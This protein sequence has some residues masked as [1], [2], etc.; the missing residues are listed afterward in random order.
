[1]DRWNIK[2]L[3]SLFALFEVPAKFLDV[4][5]GNGIMVKTAR[6]LGCEAYGVDQLVEPDWPD[7]FFH[8]NLVDYFELQNG[9]VDIVTCIEVAE[10]LHESAH[11]TFCDTICNN[12]AYGN[13]KFLIFSAA[14][15]GQDGTGHIATRP[16]HYWAEQFIMRGLT[17]N[18]IMTMNLSL[19]WSRI[20]SPLNY[21]YDNLMVFHKG[22][23]RDV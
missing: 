10:H 1:M 8:K 3:L 7:Y 6:K 14:R 22:S 20:K 2:H 23:T 11:A 15:P 16:A 12:L 19:L 13:N 5:C 18:D 4:G 21:F 9:P 17:A